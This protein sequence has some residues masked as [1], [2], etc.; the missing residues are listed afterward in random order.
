MVKLQTGLRDCA[1]SPKESRR[2]CTEAGFHESLLSHSV[3]SIENCDMTDEIF[4][5]LK[6]GRSPL[7]FPYILPPASETISKAVGMLYSLGAVD[8][9]GEITSL[10]EIFSSPKTQQ[11]RADTSLLQLCCL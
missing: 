11:V 7:D 10:G 9:T 3:P 5:I 2:M 1:S 6:L 8:G 4:T